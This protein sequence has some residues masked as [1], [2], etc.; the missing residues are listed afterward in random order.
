MRISPRRAL[1]AILAAALLLGCVPPEVSAQ[2]VRVA[3]GETGG[4]PVSPAGGFAAA[5]QM[6]P[7]LDIGAASPDGVWPAPTI[8]PS[9]VNPAVAAALSG[10]GH[11]AASKDTAKPPNAR[12][13]A[14]PVAKKSWRQRIAAVLGRKP[15]T[16]AP[17][18]EAAKAD[19]DQAFDGAVEKTGQV[20]GLSVTSPPN[21]ARRPSG[22]KAA[23]PA[24]LAALRKT[25]ADAKRAAAMA[26]IDKPRLSYGLKQGLDLVGIGA[27]LNASIRPLLDLVPWP[28]Y[29]SDH[30]LHG[31]GRVAL[32]TQY[33]PNEIAANLADS[34]A[35][36][37]AIDLPMAVTVEEVSY[38]LLN[39][40]LTF[41]AFAAIKPFAR[42]L[43]AMI[44]GLPDAAGAVSG[45]KRVLDLGVW[46]SS[47][48][49]PIAAASS[50]V[51]FAVAHFATW[52]CSPFVFIFNLSL[53]LFLAH[54]AYKSRS[55][56]SPI[57]AHLIFNLVTIGAMLIAMS[58]S[59]L[60]GE[61]FAIIAGLIGVCSLFHG[62][63]SKRKELAF[64][65]K[66][67]GKALAALLIVGAS[68]SLWQSGPT[69]APASLNARAALA[70]A[71]PRAPHKHKKAV[72]P[73]A[74]PA[75][76]GDAKAAR[77]H[78][79][80]YFSDGRIPE[81][82]ADMVARVKPA[83]VHVIVDRPGNM[84]AKGSGFILTPDGLFITNGHVV[85][86]KQPGE[87]V[88]ARVPGVDGE[89]SATVLAVNHDKD[90]AIVQLPPRLD[91]KPWPTVPLAAIPPREGEEVTAIG[92]P[93]SLPFTV[94]RGIVSG[95]DDG[96]GNIYVRELQTD[97]AVN[98]G[99]SGGPLFND[100]G[101]VVGINTEIISKG[102]G[103]DGLA[104]SIQA[105]DVASAMAQYA[106][107]GNIATASL[108]IIADLT[109]PQA[110]DAG[111]A[112]EYVRRG[113]AADTAGFRRG[114]LLIGIG[115]ESITEGG[116]EAADHVAAALAKMIP[117]QKVTIKVLRGDSPLEL[118]LTA[119]AK[120]T[121]PSR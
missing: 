47:F 100:Q 13:A 54:T 82:R 59:P 64:R 14:S 106:A 51:T 39:F 52:G 114:D 86:A 26:G 11:A 97:A 53:G 108:G 49:F 81:S 102:G 1:S 105:V 5:P 55:L 34:P 24:K 31:F 12:R 67:G 66:H 2:V 79:Q 107:T 32:L 40:G 61:A 94:T 95:L 63:L 22:L 18:V 77:P 92:Y 30:V 84:V 33:G 6:A 62:Y 91:G 4:M 70:A 60:A 65:L 58:Y 83:V 9:P 75:V 98:H 68:L 96:R 99:N 117:G 56:T 3:A 44:D 71:L 16:S 48:A 42:W 78:S 7:A 119:D 89:L 87:F 113:S 103:S 46:V 110:P 72:P 37:L 35:A 36:F 90:L 28:Q 101:E 27:I 41:L 25:L 115:A 29:L 112:I 57:L 15:A 43:S 121:T 120:T 20:A 19:A 69:S 116:Q 80:H 38:R 10:P 50:A 76:A 23:L 111:L 118:E 104:L 8:A 88:N 21:A 45:T 85:G 93:E 74:P 109:D 73:V 17:S